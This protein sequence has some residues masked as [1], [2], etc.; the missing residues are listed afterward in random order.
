MQEE[1]RLPAGTEDGIPMSVNSINQI[2][3]GALS[4]VRI[5][6]FHPLSQSRNQRVCR[7]PVRHP[8][9]DLVC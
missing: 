2:T 5:L 1:L 3:N 6:T 7:R 8:A 9:M 4:A